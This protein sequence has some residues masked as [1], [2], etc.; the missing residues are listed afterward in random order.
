MK[1]VLLLTCLFSTLTFA[2]NYQITGKVIKITDGDTVTVMTTDHS[3]YKIRLSGIDAP[4]RKQPF[5]KKSKQMLSRFIGKKMITAKCTGKDRYKRHICT[6]YLNGNDINAEMVAN[7]GAWVY[8]KHYKG[9]Y[10]YT[11]ENQA[12]VK[13]LGLWRTSE[14][15]AIPPWQWRHRKVKS[16]YYSTDTSVPVKLSR[17]GICHAVGSTYYNR[18]KRFTAY[19]TLK[20]CLRY[21]RLPRR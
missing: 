20:E 2:E 12:K 18:V 17:S 7:G 3:K 16:T 21:G 6:I 5:G 14:A 8:R 19:N 1:G 10:Y 9:S 4:E 11:L 13:K 15:Q